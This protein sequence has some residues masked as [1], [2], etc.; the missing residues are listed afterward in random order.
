MDPTE[1]CWRKSSHSMGNGGN[2]VEVADIGHAV[3]VRDSKDPGG[4][5]LRCGGR[6]WQAFVT[7]LGGERDDTRSPVRQG[8]MP[9]KGRPGQAGRPWTAR[10]PPGTVDRDGIAPS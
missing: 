3:F 5:V 2:C 1:L 6:Q 8:P 10:T 9:T 4:S 7:A